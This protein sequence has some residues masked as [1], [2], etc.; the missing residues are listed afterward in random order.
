M[1][2]SFKANVDREGFAAI[3]AAKFLNVAAF[4]MPDTILYYA[5]GFAV[6][7]T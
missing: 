2:H 3:M 7:A 6:N 5:G 4:V 1:F